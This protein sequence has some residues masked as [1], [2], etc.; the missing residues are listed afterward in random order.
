VAA[1]ILILIG[2]GWWVARHRPRPSLDGVDR[3]LSSRRYAE[4][5]Q[6]LLDYLRVHPNEAA[7]RILLARICVDR[8][9]SKPELALEQIQGVE[10]PDRR[11]AAQVKSI[12]G[13][14]RFLQQR[15]DA[16]EAAWLE[17][18]RLDPQIAEVGWGLLNLYA[19]QGRDDEAR[20]LALRL[21]E[22]EPDPH[23]RVQLLLQLI[24]HEAHA[25]APDSVAH[26]LAPVVEG[27]PGDL[28]STLALGLALVHDSRFDPGL[29]LLRRAVDA[30]REIPE[31]WASYLSALADAGQT[32]ALKRA[33]GELPAALAD[34][35]RFESARGW[36]AA[37]RGDWVAAA[38]AYRR[39]WEA[40]PGDAALAYR[41][42]TA[43]RNAGRKEELA[44]LE[45]RLQAIVA[46]REKLRPLYDQ[47]DALPD[48][49]RVPHP[50]LYLELATAL[51]HLGRHDEARAWRTLARP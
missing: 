27:N 16:A 23:D 48:L 7:A 38:R 9:D 32:D 33:L 17:A 30:H 20:R 50:E 12:E 24:R 5:E 31:T 34:D 43:L 13:E 6:R 36:I 22:V 41:L 46:S 21:Y 4:A 49:G 35:P 14:A 15:Y 10:P 25:I 29:D 19:L 3:L 11:S 51:E 1:T 39:A 40:R 47:I 18:L 44:G 8:P 37:Q 28:R 42:Q 45:P 2:L 26:Q